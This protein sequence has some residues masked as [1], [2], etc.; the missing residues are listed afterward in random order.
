MS[1]WYRDGYAA[2]VPLLRSA[3]SG[4][5]EDM[6]ADDEMRWLWLAS[7]A[8]IIVWDDESWYALSDR[9]VRLA[10]NSGAL[11][12]IPL[13]LTSRTLMLVL[14]GDLTA[15]ALLI[16]EL[17]AAMQATGVRLAPFGAIGLT[18]LRGDHA[19]AEILIDA[20]TREASQRGEGISVIA[21]WARA[22]MYNAVGHYQQAVTAAQHATDQEGVLSP[23]PWALVEL[24]E[25]AVRSGRPEIAAAALDKLSEQ[26]NAS[27]T[28]WALGV[29]ARSRALLSG[30]DTAEDLYRE[31]IERLSR[32]RVRAALARAHL[33]Y[34][35][36]LRRERRRTDAR[37]QLRQSLELLEAMGMSGFADRARRE[38]RAT[39]ASVRKRKVSAGGAALTAQENQIAR[40]AR[41]GL[42]N[43]EIGLRLF[44]SPKTVQYHL[45]KVFTKLGI[46][47]RSQLDDVLD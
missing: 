8:A 47:S 35:E 22:A 20:T 17:D 27:G 11:S 44:I 25:A 28:D 23:P 26:T 4:S 31:S 45:S 19:N 3:L 39:G 41:D 7:L 14:F 1:A 24:I 40:L 12:E 42:S 2:A 30:R 32:T 5:E 13:S 16:E 9:H 15:A 38:L 37:E 36:W 29:E 21:C 18:A 34:G 43:P 33:L 6:S 10:R 46:T